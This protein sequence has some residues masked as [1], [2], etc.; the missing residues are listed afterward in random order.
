MCGIV[1]V[2]QPEQGG[3]STGMELAQEGGTRMRRE[4]CEMCGARGGVS[5]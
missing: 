5:A 1:G 2:L 4:L 3:V